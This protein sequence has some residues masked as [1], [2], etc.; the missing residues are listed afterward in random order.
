MRYKKLSRLHCGGIAVG[1][2]RTCC[3]LRASA[4]GSGRRSADWHLRRR[5]DGCSAQCAAAIVARP[6]L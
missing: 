6:A 5:A 3:Q 2:N 1:G 4:D